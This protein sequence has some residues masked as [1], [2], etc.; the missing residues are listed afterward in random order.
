MHMLALARPYM[1]TDVVCFTRARDTHTG[2]PRVLP[3]H[4]TR[5]AKP[6]H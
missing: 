1:H 3:W 6:D 5:V 2:P 4:S